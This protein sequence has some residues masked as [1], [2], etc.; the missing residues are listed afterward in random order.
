MIPG[1]AANVKKSIN[2]LKDLIENNSEILKETEQ[3]ANAQNE[4]SA[5]VN[6]Q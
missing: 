3:W 2:E 1:A 6:I 5:A 4:I